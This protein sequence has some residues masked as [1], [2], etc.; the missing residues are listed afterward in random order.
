MT[1]EDF[2]KFGSQWDGPWVEQFYSRVLPRTSGVT[3]AGYTHGWSKIMCDY[4]GMAALSCPEAMELKIIS[5]PTLEDDGR[6]TLNPN[7]KRII[8]GEGHDSDL[9]TADAIKWTLNLI[10]RAKKQ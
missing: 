8:W 10:E 3:L 9:I 6:Y 4:A 2:Q 5:A 1:F 7:N